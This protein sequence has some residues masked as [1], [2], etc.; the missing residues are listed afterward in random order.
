MSL[1]L[2][3]RKAFLGCALV[4]A[5][6]LAFGQASYETNGTEYA[7]AGTLAGDQVHPQAALTASGGYLVWADNITDGSGLGISAVRLDSS[8]SA[9]YAPFRVNATGAADQENP[10][11]S[12]LQGGGAAFVWQGGR[13]GYQHIYARFLSSSG[14]WLSTQDLLVNAQTNKSQ[15]NPALATLANNNVVVLYA[16]LNQQ[17]S[18]SLQDVYGQLLS[19]T[20]AKIGSEFAVNQFTAFNQRTPAVAALNNGGFI[21]V[22]ISEQQRTTP[23]D[24]SNTDTI[25]SPTNLPS[26][27]VYARLFNASGMPVGSEFLV[28]SS[29][30]V[31][32][33]P[34][35]AVG[36][37]GGFVITW[38]QKNPLMHDYG[39][40]VC[41]RPYSAAAV[42]GS[43]QLVNT[44][45]YG[46]QYAP[47]IS[48]VGTDFLIVW[49]SLGQDGSREGVFGHLLRG[50]GTL[51]GN[52]FRVNTTTVNQ[53]KQPSVASDGSG[54]FL[55]TWTSYVG[56]VGSVDLFAQRYVN[57]AQPLLAMNAPFVN[58][59][60]RLVSNIYQPQIE[61][62][63][64]VQA[65]LAIDH[66]QVYV[67]GSPAAS[68]TTNVWVMNNVAVSS[69]HS[70]AVAYVTT[71]GRQ[72]PL[73]AAT[74]ASAWSGYSWGGIPFEWV[75]TY[76]GG[77]ANMLQWPNPEAPLV[78]GGPT[79]LQVFLS[80]GNPL[81]PTT[82]LQTKLV[83]SP[84]GLF[85]LWNPQ[86]GLTYQVQGSADLSHWSNFGAPRFA[87]GYSD[88]LYVGGQ[89]LAYYR[90]LVLR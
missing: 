43:V 25:Y 3:A 16:S 89:N 51:F 55:V 8:F 36:S 54:R 15:L 64:P 40:D 47:K 28:N 48:A 30:N 19:P 84:Q 5:S 11:V 49:T 53:Q 62:S 88:S 78:A 7:I 76:Y 67:D 20:G 50:N 61:V 59:P 9:A 22:W 52:E 4:L 63:W 44:Y 24:G 18:N 87:A 14:T 33:N 32:A 2:Y 17:S 77:Q 37:D 26:V 60:F 57:V 83:P 13:L 42:G 31:C 12:L 66:Y 38:S 75:S 23:V 6:G 86:P 41:A 35:V 39:W 34:Q 29:F 70:F 81:N 68:V 72:S 69:L 27:D 73:S 79:L 65:G 82:W 74:S 56:G 58:V 80:G 10:Q 46:D 45:Q 71:D 21:A 85:L 1:S 90:V